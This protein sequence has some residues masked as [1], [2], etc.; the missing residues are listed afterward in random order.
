MTDGMN[1]GKSNFGAFFK[2]W[3][4]AG[5]AG[6][7][8]ATPPEVPAP[9]PVPVAPVQPGPAAPV[10]PTG[11]VEVPSLPQPAAAAA[12]VQVPPV[13]EE[14]VLLTAPASANPAPPAPAA[15]PTAA[16]EFVT[17]APEA[18][19]LVEEQGGSEDEEGETEDTDEEVEEVEEEE[20]SEATTPETAEGEA[21]TVPD[22][23]DAPE[24]PA[25]SGEV[26]GHLTSLMSPGSA[27]AFTLSLG[28]D[29]RLTAQV[30]PLNLP[31]LRELTLTGMVEEFDSAE[32]L[33]ALREYRPAVQGSLREQAR[34]QAKATQTKAATPSPAPT[35]ASDRHKGKLKIK[36]DVPGAGL[37]AT[38]GGHGTT[39]QIGDNDLTPGR[40]TIEASAEGYKTAKQTVKVER[41]KTAE[42]AFTLGGSLEVQAPSGAAV[43]V[44][45]SAGNAVNPAGPLPEGMYKVLVEAEHKKPFTWHAT[46]K[47][48]P[49]TK[50]T[51]ML[52]DAPPTL[53]GS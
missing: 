16:P 39:V 22:A 11:G 12:P 32:L 35:P 42:L 41:G 6:P 13:P 8:P 48:G 50:V 45:D 52:D 10:V 25:P 37:K 27:L 46:V 29:G 28:E 1:V 51:A 36:V 3:G 17:P 38:L 15:P 5:T 53:F 14:P 30:K 7:A 43:T 34:S 23:V 2:N 21:S 31:G 47:A 9:Q 20:S 49:P 33:Y 19:S 4:G 24:L 44:F 18:P 26:F 40:Y